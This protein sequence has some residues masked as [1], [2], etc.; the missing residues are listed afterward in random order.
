M[1]LGGETSGV[2][3]LLGFGLAFAVTAAATPL[4]RRYALKR[5]IVDRPD[6]TVAGGGR[7]IHMQPVAYLGGVAIFAGFLVAVVALMPASRQL[8]ALIAGCLILV[9]VGVVDDIRG[10][11]PW[12]KLGF[13]FLAA[14]VALAGG[15]GIT[16]ITNPF[17]GVIDLT[18]GRFPV[19]LGPWHFHIAPLANGLSLLWMVGLANTINFLDGLDGLASGVSGIAAVVMFALAVGPHVHQPTVALLAII[20]AGAAFGFL[21]YHFYPARIFMGDSGAYFLGL[22]LAMLAVFSGAKLATAVLVLGVPIVDSLWAVTR[23]LAKRTSPFRADKK[24]FHHLLLDAGMSQRQAVLTVYAVAAAFG[25]VALMVGSFAKLMALVALTTFMAAAIAL[26]ILIGW[27][28]RRR[29]LPK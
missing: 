22:C 21:P 12:V 11:S 13:Q 23:R 28:K 16:A 6:T 14:G 27:F 10:L 8:A 25:T 18:V 26:L 5:G 20:L 19:E 1:I 17:G 2:S 7:K 24:H 4:V 29:L 3:Y 15:I 9:A